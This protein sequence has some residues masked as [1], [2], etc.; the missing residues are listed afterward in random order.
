MKHRLPPSSIGATGARAFALLLPGP[1]GAGSVDPGASIKA[2][3]C[4]CLHCAWGCTFGSG[5]GSVSGYSLYSQRITFAF[6]IQDIWDRLRLRQSFPATGSGG[7]FRQIPKRIAGGPSAWARRMSAARP[8]GER[9][10]PGVH[11]SSAILSGQ[12]E[13][14]TNFI[15]FHKIHRRFAFGT[16][17]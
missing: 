2:R 1:A 6:F 15:Q 14:K 9:S 13:S 8:G 12:D 5:S 10:T 3:H 4:N 17:C 11:G 16:S 7:R